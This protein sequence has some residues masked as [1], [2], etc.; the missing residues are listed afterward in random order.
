M[1]E[2]IPIQAQIDEVLGCY[3]NRQAW[4]DRRAALI[5]Q[6]KTVPPDTGCVLASQPGLDAA[7]RTL[8]W[9]RDNAD[10][11][12]AIRQPDEAAA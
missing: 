4:L 9:V 11:L 2:R 12:R 10:A 8:E 3:V 5:A 1:A 7:V 6:G